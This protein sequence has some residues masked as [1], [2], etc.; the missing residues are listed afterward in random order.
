MTAARISQKGLRRVTAGHP[1]IFR[2]D[3][4]RRPARDAGVV[5]V[6][7]YRGKPIGWAL[8]SPASEISL[9]MLDRDPAATI[10]ARWWYTR[11]GRAV[12]RRAPLAS[13]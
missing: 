8:W 4:E 6:E 11:I 5:A 3:V 12:E 2:S 1:W 10:D 7:D 13:H 9:R